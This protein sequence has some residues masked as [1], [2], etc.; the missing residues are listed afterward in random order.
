MLIVPPPPPHL[1]LG[2]DSET[3]L[4]QPGRLAP[5]LV[6]VSTASRIVVPTVDDTV[7]RFDRLEIEG[8][9]RPVDTREVSAKS[10]DEN[11]YGA[12][13]SVKFY[14]SALVQPNITLII[15]NAPFDLG[16][17]VNEDFS[18]MPLVFDAFRA[19][20]IICTIT[21]QKVIDV[22]KGMRKFRR[23]KRGDRVVVTQAAYGLDDLIDYYYQE[24]VEKKDTWRLSYAFL[25]NIP[26]SQWPP[27]A[28]KYAIDDAVRHLRLFEA[29]ER[30]IAANI[31]G[32]VLP[33]QLE[34]QIAS[35]ALHLMSMWGLRADP[36]AAEYFISHCEE[37][38]DKMRAALANTG[39]LKPGGSKYMKEIKRRVV[40]SFNRMG[41]S[42]PM[43][44]P[45]AKHPLGQVRTNEDT[46]RLT[47][48]MNL[49]V[50]ADSLKFQKHLG[51]WGPVV[52][53]ACVRAVCCSYNVLVDNGRTSAHGAQGQDGTN[54]QN[55]PRQGDVRPCFIPRPGW[56]YV[57][58]DADTVEMRA[59][60][61]NC[62][63]MVGWSRMAEALWDQAKNNG[64]DLHVCLAASTLGISKEA[65][66]L[67]HKSGDSSFKNA[68]QMNKHGN[69][70]FL[71]GAGA[72]RFAG[73]AHGFGI[74]LTKSSD[75]PYDF[76]DPTP[77]FVPEEDKETGKKKIATKW[78]SIEA[79]IARAREIKRSF[80][81]TWPEMIEYFRIIT[82]MIES[83]R[84]ARQL[85][86]GRIRGD[87]RFTSLANT[88][89][90]GRV[91]DAFKEIVVNLADECYTGRCTSKHSHGGD[92]C[93]Y[94]GRTVLEGSRP[95]LFLH[96]EPIL[97]HPEATMS[98]RAEKQRL[99]VVEGLEAWMP[100]VPCTS[101]AVAMRRWQKGAD[102]LKIDGK[103]VPV[104]P[105]KVEGKVKWVQDFG[106]ELLAA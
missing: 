57:S 75:S 28:R 71:G 42:V 78:V 72:E 3:E 21:K 94:T 102:P 67:L 23:V 46:L 89:F 74:C 15:H 88:F 95:A 13:D 8:Y 91:A 4:I 60:A 52:T 27:S 14:H 106:E 101:S 5:T 93:T 70:A 40:E 69:F 33:N 68:R 31:E 6:C 76:S 37:Q 97:E 65:A 84:P 30:D 59:N 100:G 103:L 80:L 49:H 41:M 90:S 73:M 98:E 38:I 26:V 17:A 82:M 99:V 47:D 16:V 62:L 56:I 92:F 104:K 2:V 12:S 25:K 48:D 83:G 55:P 79:E 64:P 32:G 50:L 36:K 85:K 54:I 86:S 53:A 35:W 105:L 39:I 96:D 18:L 29:Q 87:L 9:Q 24:Y 1:F 77:V 66:H 34:Q 44:K 58:T 7:A 20:R 43:S 45:S 10:F 81:M 51:Q 63:E 19:G 22:A 11:L 61:Q